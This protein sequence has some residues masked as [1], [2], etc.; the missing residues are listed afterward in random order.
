MNLPLPKADAVTAAQ[1]RNWLERFAE[2][3]VCTVIN[4]SPTR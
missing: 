2:A 3:A 4:M 1:V